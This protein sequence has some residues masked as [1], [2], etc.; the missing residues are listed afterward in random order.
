V[1]NACTTSIFFFFHS[2]FFLSSKFIIFSSRSFFFFSVKCVVVN[3]CVVRWFRFFF[4]FKIYLTLILFFSSYLEEQTN[5]RE[6]KQNIQL[7]IFTFSFFFFL[8]FSFSLFALSSHII[9]HSRFFSLS[10]LLR[11]IKYEEKKKLQYFKDHYD[12]IFNRSIG[13]FSNRMICH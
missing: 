7:F 8:L 13:R 4:L 10:Q 11:Q 2:F 9:I 1:I 5:T 6:I 12:M 3:K